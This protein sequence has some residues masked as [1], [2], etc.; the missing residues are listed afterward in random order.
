MNER[1]LTAGVSLLP[2]LWAMEPSRFASL[3]SDKFQPQALEAALVAYWDRHSDETEEE[4][5]P[6]T[7]RNGVARLDLKGPLVKEADF[8]TW[9]FGGTSLDAFSCALRKA[10][11]D[12]EVTEILLVIDSPGGTLDGT[13]A[14]A[15]A[16]NEAKRLKKVN[17][18]ADGCCCSAAYWIAS[19]CHTLTANP[20]SDMANVGIYM[21]VTDISEMLASEGIKV[22]LFATGKY[23]GAGTRGVALTEAHSEQFQ[24]MVSA[25]FALFQTAVQQG[26]NLTASRLKTVSDGKVYMAQNA[27]DL[28]LLDRVGYMTDG[29]PPQAETPDTDTEGD[30]PAPPDTDSE[31]QTMNPEEQKKQSFLQWLFAGFNGGQPTAPQ[32]SGDATEPPPTDVENRGSQIDSPLLAALEAKRQ[33]EDEVLALKAANDEL[34]RELNAHKIDALVAAGIILPAQR[35]AQATLRLLNPEAFDAAMAGLAP[36]VAMGGGETPAPAAD[37]IPA[38]E[39]LK[40]YQQQAKGSDGAHASV[41]DAHIERQNKLADLPNALTAR[42]GGK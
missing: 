1:F 8:W 38:F 25:P 10:A 35:D 41:V 7:I 27:L 22:N 16:V 21:T 32:A 34:K 26:R 28:G 40:A 33:A 20:E 31:E 24:D 39:L 5:K 18:H 2:R 23:K 9:W 12:E 42:M 6:Y 29:V 13:P 17:A 36:H 30:P 4:R 37:S 15:N 11:A 3:L 19:Q 14:A